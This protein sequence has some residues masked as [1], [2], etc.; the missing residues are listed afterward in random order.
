[1]E[2]TME[3]NIPALSILPEVIALYEDIPMKPDITTRNG[4]RLGVSCHACDRGA[5]KHWTQA[6]VHLQEWSGSP[7]TGESRASDHHHSIQVQWR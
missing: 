4:E 3:D 1:M 5:D 6:L 2:L 7:T